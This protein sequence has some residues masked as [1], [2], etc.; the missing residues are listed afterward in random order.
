MV[1]LGMNVGTDAS[2]EFNGNKTSTRR[3][4]DNPIC[5][6]EESGD[7]NNARS[8]EDSS[9]LDPSSKTEYV[10]SSSYATLS[11][12]APLVPDTSDDDST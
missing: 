4:M 5:I 11:S 10:A 1:F 8:E 9:G 7:D 3:T 6:N 12:D 2:M